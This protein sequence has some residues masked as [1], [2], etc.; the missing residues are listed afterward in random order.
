MN[1]MM[2]LHCLLLAYTEAVAPNSSKLIYRLLGFMSHAQ[3]ASFHTFTFHRH[4]DRSILL[5]AVA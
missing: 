2:L 1:L 4:C 5:F 3:T